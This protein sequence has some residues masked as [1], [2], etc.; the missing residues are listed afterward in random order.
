VIIRRA[1]WNSAAARPITSLYLLGAALVVAA[2]LGA[3]L[4][5]EWGVRF[6]R[7]FQP[8]LVIHA[9]WRQQLLTVLALV[10]VVAAYRLYRAYARKLRIFKVALKRE[11]D[12]Q[13]KFEPEVVRYQNQAR[14]GSADAKPG[15]GAASAP[16][17]SREKGSWLERSMPRPFMAG[18]TSAV[19]GASARRWKTIWA[20]EARVREILE[21]EAPQIIHAHDVTS[22]AVCADVRRSSGCRLIFD[23]HEVYDHL[24]QTE[25]ELAEINAKV[26][27]KYADRVD[28]L[29]TINE[30]IAGYYRNHY[31]GLPRA[32]IVKNA[33]PRT[34]TF[35][36]DGRLHET[37]KLPR[38]QS[39]LIYQGGYAPKRGLLQLLLAAEYL[40]PRWALVFMGWGRLEPELRRTADALCTRVTS[41]A[42]RIRF[43]PKVPQRELP[44]W[45]A[46]ATLGA[47]PYE[48]AGLNHWFCTPN[49]LWEYPNAGVPIIASP[50]PELQRI[51]EPNSIGW[52]LP[53]PLTP[54]EIGKAVNAL[55]PE[56][57]AYAKAA[58]SEFIARDNWSV[59][60]E[61]LQQAYR[62]LP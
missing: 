55:T 41:L 54:K 62:G 57:L 40:E 50:F 29:I 26:M 48:N 2:C 3:Y 49:K 59:Y 34:D 36:Y 46:G 6:A 56:M 8:T 10:A 21:E 16:V 19:S 12:E 43:I 33:A 47:I 18:L 7:D 5:V 60:R 30:S 35:Q 38:E 14:A 20:R 61:R 27:R 22:L 32:T 24:A 44:Y 37:A 13:L 15:S 52:F 25:E 4:V 45:T 58:C 53:D 51:I 9:G 39:I 28:A 31:R 1:A 17:G 23:A 11:D 42:E